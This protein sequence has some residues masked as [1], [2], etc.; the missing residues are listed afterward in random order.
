MLI[1]AHRQMKKNAKTEK[2]HSCRVALI[3]IYNKHIM[4]FFCALWLHLTDDVREHWTDMKRDECK[5]SV[6][7]VASNGRP[8]GR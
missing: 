6:G 8:F 1:T 2:N 5:R 3:L 7:G 4:G